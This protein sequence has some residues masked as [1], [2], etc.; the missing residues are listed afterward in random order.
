M[1]KALV[2][3]V[4]ATIGTTPLIAQDETGVRFGMKLSP[5]L[6]FVNP[7]TRG[8]SS[9]GANAGYTFGL[10]AEFPIGTSGNYQ[11]ATGLNLNNVSGAWN[12]TFTYADNLSGPS[13]T[14]DLETNVKLRY[15]ELPL[16]IKMMTNE[17]GYMR[18][19]GQV[20]FG[21]AVNIRAK[22]DFIEPTIVDPT[23]AGTRPDRAPIVTE[24]TEVEN[25]DVQDDINPY[26]ASLI[27]AAGMEYNFSGN[28]SLL[29]AVTYN[30]GFTDILKTD[31]VKA[32]A[33]YL[34]LTV[35][36]FF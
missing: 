31:D 3:L 29:V 28:T 19:F 26:K 8:Y 25:E 15:I 21:N 23:I 27:V 4:A 22:A 36:I 16:T 11:F 32:M 14:R 35:G 7:D 1:K 20:G 18:Y 17:I 12:E 30:N 34:E 13:R 24:F 9:S 5:N 2:I 33:N 6:G 10:M